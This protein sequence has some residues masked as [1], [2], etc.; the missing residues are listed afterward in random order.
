MASRASGPRP[1]PKNHDGAFLTQQALVASP[2]LEPYLGSAD[3]VLIALESDLHLGLSSTQARE[4][5]ARYGSNELAQ[6]KPVS[7]WRKFLAQF[8][9]PL[10]ILLV[11]A[12]L[13]FHRSVGL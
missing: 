2:E 4:R 5:L 7:A 1:C 11:V 3:S 9:D 12:A 6:E 13:Y 10:V 8:G